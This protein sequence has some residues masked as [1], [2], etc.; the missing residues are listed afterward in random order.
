MM[1]GSFKLPKR[2]VVLMVVQQIDEKKDSDETVK[3][4]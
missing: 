3:G 1:E 4:G 2:C